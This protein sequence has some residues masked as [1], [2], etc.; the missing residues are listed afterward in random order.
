MDIESREQ[1]HES[2]ELRYGVSHL[3][4]AEITLALPYRIVMH[5]K[6]G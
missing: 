5:S 3:V 1:F 4:K 6:G 2:H